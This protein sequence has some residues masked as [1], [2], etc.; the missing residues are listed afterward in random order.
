MTG[1]RSNNSM[2]RTALCAA[3]AASRRNRKRGPVTLTAWREST[4]R[5][6]SRLR[7][8]EL[9][10]ATVFRTVPQGGYEDLAAA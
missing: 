6:L 8:G 1:T 5:Q 7:P 4:T 3:L 10:A 9:P 2:Q